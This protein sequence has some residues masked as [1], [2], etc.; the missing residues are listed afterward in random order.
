MMEDKLKERMVEAINLNAHFVLETALS[1]PDYW[2]YIDMFD[3][4]GYR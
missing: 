4:A 2:G 1:N 3:N